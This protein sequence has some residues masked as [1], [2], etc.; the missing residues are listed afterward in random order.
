MLE[1]FRRT[2]SAVKLMDRDDLKQIDRVLRLL[3]DIESGKRL[4]VAEVVRRLRGK[5][6]RRLT[7]R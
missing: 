5:K 2:S 4:E 6:H 7:R 3:E 1:D